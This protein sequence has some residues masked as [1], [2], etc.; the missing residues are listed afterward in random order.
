MVRSNRSQLL[1]KIGILKKSGKK[2][3][4]NSAGVTF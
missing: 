1:Y 4:N 3:E 2:Q